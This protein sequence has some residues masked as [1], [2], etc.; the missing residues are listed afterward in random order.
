MQSLPLQC[1]PIGGH[2]PLTATAV[3]TYRGSLQCSS[4]GSAPVRRVTAVQQCTLQCSVRFSGQPANLTYMLQLLLV[5][6]LVLLWQCSDLRLDVASE[7]KC[8]MN[9]PTSTR[10]DVRVC[11]PCC[12]RSK[13]ETR[14]TRENSVSCSLAS[15][16]FLFCC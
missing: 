1:T 13:P 7:A 6:M 15:R 3:H 2:C 4:E 10:T 8:K 11:L 12:K 9:M 5:L 14:K 16:P